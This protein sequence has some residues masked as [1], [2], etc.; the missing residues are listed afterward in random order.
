MNMNRT[1]KITDLEDN[2]FE[3]IPASHGVPGVD[4]FKDADDIPII[5]LTL[6]NIKELKKFLKKE[7]L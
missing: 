3:F 5:R 1:L 2:V 6:D 4:V 7:Y